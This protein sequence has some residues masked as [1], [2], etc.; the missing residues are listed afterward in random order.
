M[1]TLRHGAKGLRFLSWILQVKSV[2][3]LAEGL[4]DGDGLVD[5]VGEGEQQVP[6]FTCCHQILQQ[7]VDGDFLG[8]ETLAQEDHRAGEPIVTV[9][10][11]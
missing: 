4:Q 5:V 9:V 1:V 3:L 10:T 7:G 6:V 2:S 11:L 8:P